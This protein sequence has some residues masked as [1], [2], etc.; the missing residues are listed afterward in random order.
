MTRNM[1]VLSGGL[2]STS[3]LAVALREHPLSD[4]RAVSFHYGQ[5]HAV[6][7][8]R[9]ERIAHLLSVPHQIVSLDGLMSGSALL[10]ETD[11]PEGHYAEDS[12]TATVVN[13]RNLLFASAAVAQCQPGDR[14]WM[15]VH[16]GDHPIYPDCRPEFWDALRVVVREAYEV[17]IVTPFLHTSK[18]E[19]A[20]MGH[21]AGAPL[22]LTWS[23]YNGGDRH[24]G[25]CGTC[26][27]RAEAF[28]LAG[29]DDPTDYVDADF[30]R[31][32]TASA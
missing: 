21:E 9:A 27:E 4:T 26:V 8:G 12:M 18:A 15:G 6:E 29:L 28:D 1:I 11:V 3:A 13:G 14:L 25:R 16:A 22:G 31:A 32:A 7:L 19:V 2:D 10:G 23:C 20:R 30:W 5:R 17:E 24:C